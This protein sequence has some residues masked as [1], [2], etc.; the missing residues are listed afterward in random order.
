MRPVDLQWHRRPT[1]LETGFPSHVVGGSGT[2]TPG[3][4]ILALRVI[5]ENASASF[6]FCSVRVLGD[7]YTNE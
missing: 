3:G 2:L 4:A 6:I 1:N 7:R 5:L